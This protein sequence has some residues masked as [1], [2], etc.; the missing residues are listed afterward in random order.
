MRPGRF[1]G[2]EFKDVTET[3]IKHLQTWLAEIGYS[4]GPVDGQFNPRM[5]RAVRHFQVHF[6][7]RSD[8]DTIN[9]QTAVLIRA[10]RDA[11]PKAD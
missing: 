1:G 3:P 4:V 7:G 2:R 9:A 11:N 6:E 8:N 5:A 10:V